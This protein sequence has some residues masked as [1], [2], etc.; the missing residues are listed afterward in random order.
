MP[1]LPGA[2][3]M[4]VF[5]LVREAG[6]DREGDPTPIDPFTFQR[7]MWPGSYFY[8]KQ[9]ELIL[10]ACENDETVCVAGNMLGKDFTAGFLVLY[11]FL[12]RKPC[13]VVTTSAKDEHLRVLWGEI[14][15]WIARARYPLEWKRGGPLIVNHQELRKVDV[16]TGRKCP[17]SYVIGMV[18]SAD[19]IAAMQ[20]HHV[21]NV[22]DGVPRTLFVSDESSSVPDDYWNMAQRWANRM[23]AIGNPLPCN[24]FF[25]RADKGKPGTNDKG[26]DVPREKD[27]PRGGYYRKVIRIRATDSPNVRL[28]LAQQAAGERPTGEVIVPGVKGWWEYRKNRATMHPADQTVALD[29]EFYEGLEAKLFPREWLD[30][31]KEYGDELDELVRRGRLKRVARAMGVDPGEG[32]DKSA[33]VVGDEYGV[34]KVVAKRTPDTNEIIRTTLALRK[35]YGVP[36]DRVYIDRGGGGKQHADRL[37]EDHGM[38]GV[39]TVGFGEG[40]SQEPRRGRTQ[41]RERVDVKESRYAYKNRRAELYGDLSDRLDPSRGTPFAIPAFAQAIHNQLLPIPRLKDPEDRLYLPPKN[42]PATAQGKNVVS[43]VDLIGHSPDEADALVLMLHALLG[44]GYRPEA[45]AAV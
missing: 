29:A 16:K 14:G 17:L 9:R 23:V 43:L 28:A 22:G 10:S 21:A 35:E 39:V 20:G 11:F 38:P 13:R 24:N 34:L 5:D 4:S 40:V 2:Y 41:Y 27:D 33:W 36:D 42:R 30:R 26:G 45:G 37:R 31:A 3:R 25:Y 7:V 32:G 6:Y 15:S 18:A 19:T 12:T 8:D 44:K 1:E